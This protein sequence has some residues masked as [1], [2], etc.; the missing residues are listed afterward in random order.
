MLQLQQGFTSASTTMLWEIPQRG[1]SPLYTIDIC[2]FIAQLCEDTVSTTFPLRHCG[3]CTNTL[4]W[5]SLFPQG[6]NDKVLTSTLN[7]SLSGDRIII[8]YIIKQRFSQANPN[9]MLVSKTG[10]RKGE[11]IWRVTGR[12]W[13]LIYK[14]RSQI[15]PQRLRMSLWTWNRPQISV[16]KARIE[17]MSVDSAIQ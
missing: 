11:I 4:G 3:S 2:G 7:L 9:A 6:W 5:D 8:D 10:T 16:S 12:D 15:F 1:S 17:Y 14:L 13:S